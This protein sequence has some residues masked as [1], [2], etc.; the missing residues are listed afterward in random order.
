ME[1]R[2]R[3]GVKRTGQLD[4]ALGPTRHNAANLGSPKPWIQP[5]VANGSDLHWW[6]E[7][8]VEP[9]SSLEQNLTLRIEATPQLVRQTA[10]PKVDR[11]SGR[12][13]TGN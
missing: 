12:V 10:L 2:H 5:A 6:G 1:G 4:H 8:L 9:T 7:E 13:D 3:A 11:E